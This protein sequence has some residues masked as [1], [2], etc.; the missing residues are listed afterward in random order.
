MQHYLAFSFCI[1]NLKLELGINIYRSAGPGTP[2]G[3]E[4]E[5]LLESVLDGKRRGTR[6]E[7]GRR[8]RTTT[9]AP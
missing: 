5:Q 1:S 8:L 3:Q 4:A 6:K 2:F 7:V 9:R